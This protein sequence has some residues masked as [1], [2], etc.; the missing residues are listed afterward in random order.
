MPD[1]LE[2]HSDS[3]DYGHCFWS[4]SAWVWLLS[5]LFNIWT[6]YLTSLYLSFLISKMRIIIEQWKSNKLTYCLAYSRCSII[7]DIILSHKKVFYT[8][9]WC[10]R[11]ER[12]SSIIC[13]PMWMTMLIWKQTSSMFEIHENKISSL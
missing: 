5:S 1:P 6:N 9:L 4:Y 13:N 2:F 3:I 12:K 11:R 7:V 10:H 8:W